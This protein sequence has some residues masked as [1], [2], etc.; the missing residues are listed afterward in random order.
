VHD[1][2][3]CSVNPCFIA[4]VTECN[5]GGSFLVLPI[6]HIAHRPTS[7]STS[8]PLEI[9]PPPPPPPPLEDPTSTSTSTSTPLEIPTSTSTSTPL[10]IP[11]SN[12]TC[13][14]AP[15]HPPTGRVP[16]HH[17]RVCG[18]RGRVLDVKWSPFNDHQVASCSED[19]T[20]K[21]WDIPLCGVR[22]N[23][24]QARKTLIG[25]SRRVGLIEWH[26][27]AEDLLLTSAYDYKV[28]LWDVSGAGPVLRCP[29]RVVVSP[30]GQPR[31]AELLLRC[32]CFSPDGSRLA[33]TSKDRRLRLLDPR[34]GL[35]LQVSSHPD[36]GNLTQVSSSSYRDLSEPLYEE[37]LEGTGGVLF[38]FFDPDTNML[39]LAGKQDLSE[40]LY[41]EELEG[42]GG[43]LFPFFDPDTNM[44]YLAGKVLTPD[45]FCNVTPD[46]FCNVT[47]DRFCNVTP[48]PFCNV[49]PDRFCNVTPE[50]GDGN[51]RYYERGLDVRACELFRFYR[52][53]P[54]KHLVQ[55]VSMLVERARKSGV[56]QEDLYPLT[57]GNSASLT[58]QQWLSGLNRGP[59][60]MSLRP[61]AVLANPYP[62]TP[63]D[64]Q[65]CPVGLVAAR[66]PTRPVEEDAKYPRTGSELPGWQPDETQALARAYCVIPHCCEPD[67]TP[68]PHTESQVFYRQQE[69]IRELREELGQKEEKISQL[70]MEIR[71]T[72]VLRTSY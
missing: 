65:A 2:H 72:A 47:P 28:C 42:T 55:P 61:G 67:E 68:P 40:P 4:V 69:E 27:T 20:V 56:F 70:Q 3:Y 50:P 49:T 37:E 64:P 23:L 45:R 24:T 71:N 22:Q 66:T 51:I 58:A 60:L 9:P 63:P 48:D 46:R 35:I 31:A 5:G 41:E 6:N 21:I 7:T 15:P 29:V 25:H 11:T 12:L 10:E 17:P 32:A 53:V 44:L 59:V 54:S 34:T 8:T 13:P 57:A 14:P 43:V 36:P 33:L 39:Y 62:E 26:P 38:P 18:H 1:N 19:C 52:L 30:V 16:A